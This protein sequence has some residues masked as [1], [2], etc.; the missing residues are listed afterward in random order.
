MAQL[1][2]QEL[3]RLRKTNPYMEIFI[4]LIQTYAYVNEPNPHEVWL[5]CSLIE[6]RAQHWGTNMPEGDNSS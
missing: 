2:T 5:A 6:M 3:D 1:T 4:P